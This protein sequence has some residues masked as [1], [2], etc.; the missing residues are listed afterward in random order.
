MSRLL[1]VSAALVAALAGAGASWWMFGGSD[2][3]DPIAACRG[4]SVATGG[5]TVGGP[6]TLI[7]ETGREVTEAD[8][9]DRPALIYFGYTFCPDVC[10]Y[11]VARNADAAWI[12]EDRGIE[13]RP[14]F[15][16]IDPE[17]DTPEV[18]DAFTEM[19]HP[20]MVGL[21]GSPEQVRLAAN[22]YRVFFQKHEAEGDDPFY[23]VDHSTFSYFMMPGLGFVEFFRRDQGAADMADR[24]QCYI[25]AVESGGPPI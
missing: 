16:T 10:P 12:L 8:I 23:L 5:G 2:G 19:M 3:G 7:D 20:R 15:I 1:F 22:A 11:D 14:V 17:R 24:I 21:T 4:S 6:F 9:L 13:L 25:E 18:L